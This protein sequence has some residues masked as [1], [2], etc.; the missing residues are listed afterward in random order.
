MYYFPIQLGDSV[1]PAYSKKPVW[2]KLAIQVRNNPYVLLRF[3]LLHTSFPLK[4]SLL[5]FT[6]HSKLSVRAS[7]HLRRNASS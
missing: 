4:N 7:N 5:K 6:V 2:H 3:L 1:H